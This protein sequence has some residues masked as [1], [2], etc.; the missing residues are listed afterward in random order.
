MIYVGI[1]M[2]IS[3]TVGILY[4]AFKFEDYFIA[5]EGRVFGKV[6]TVI[7]VLRHR[8]GRW[9]L[10]D[11]ERRPMSEETRERIA[12]EYAADNGIIFMKKA[13]TGAKITSD[14]AFRNLLIKI[15][16]DL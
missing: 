3:S 2:I 13:Q 16:G 7:K 9:L 10:R 1:V 12:F 15:E 6:K 14:E 5:L 11:L 4:V 8:L